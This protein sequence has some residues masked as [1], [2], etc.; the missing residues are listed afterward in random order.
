MN[1]T[2]NKKFL[3]LA[4]LLGAALPCPVPAQAADAPPAPA[5]LV[6][7]NSLIRRVLPRQ[8]DR[9]S[10]ELMPAADGN[11]VFEIEAKADQVVLRGNSGLSL[12]MAFNWYLR[13]EAKADF[14][15]MDTALVEAKPL[16]KASFTEWRTAFE[17][18]WLN[19]ADPGFATTPKGDPCE[20][21][22]RLLAKSR[23]EL[24]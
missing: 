13:H 19:A 8:A 12:A 3:P 22:S 7:A 17:E 6:A 1:K 11:D 24:R 18:R 4:L 14:D 9:F 20:L 15:C 2:I 16:D 21:A 5:G 23:A 10:V